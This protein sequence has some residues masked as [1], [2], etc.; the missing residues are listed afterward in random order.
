MV[1]ETPAYTWILLRGLGR[2]KGHWGDFSEK[3][4]QRMSGDEVLAIDLPGTGE[5]LDRTSPTSLSGILNQVRGEAIARAR[6]PRQFK[7]LA[8]SLGGMVAMEWMR[9]KPEDIAGC[10]LVNT[11]SGSVSPFYNRLRWQVWRDLLKV[12]TIQSARERERAIIQ[13]LFNNPEARETALPQWTKIAIERP[14]SYL[15][16]FNQLL[17]ASRF[18]GVDRDVKVPV[19]LLNGLGDRFV[20]P[21]CSTELHEAMGWPILRHPWAGHDLP[22]DDPEWMLEKISTWRIANA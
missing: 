22:W 1:N 9:Q 4:A 10:V 12:M 21:S 17:A 11:S 6:E 15:C 3:F 2:E 18:K 7:L 14:V 8:M 13:I 19:L 16:F 5:H 20:D